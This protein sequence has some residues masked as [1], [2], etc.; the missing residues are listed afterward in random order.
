MLFS[1]KIKV[2]HNI[3]CTQYYF[4]GRVCWF[5]F[6]Q[7]IFVT[8][9]SFLLCI[10]VATT[11]PIRLYISVDYFSRQ[12]LA[13]KN[14]SLNKCRCVCLF[15]CVHVSYMCVKCEWVCAQ[16]YVKINVCSRSLFGI[17]SKCT[18]CGYIVFV[19]IT[20]CMNIFEGVGNWLR[21]WSS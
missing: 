8:M 10:F 4:E 20:F 15:Q 16:R 11:E 14:T 7:R 13:I 2:L 19:N 18:Y 17:H 3:F 9:I 12:M 21:S 1:S 5:L 6:W